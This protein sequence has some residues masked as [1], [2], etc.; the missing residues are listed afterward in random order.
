MISLQ[1]YTFFGCNDPTD[2]NEIQ[3][4]WRACALNDALINDFANLLKDPKHSDV[5]INCVGGA[6][7]AHKCILSG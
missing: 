3:F 2:V 7:K 6:V 5:T 1:L 4:Y